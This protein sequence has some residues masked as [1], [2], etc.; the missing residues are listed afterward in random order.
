MSKEIKLKLKENKVT[1]N[2]KNCEDGI[3]QLYLLMN[4]VI[5]ILCEIKLR[6]NLT[7]IGMEEYYNILLDDM[8][9][10]VFK[11]LEEIKNEKD[12]KYE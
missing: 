2:S 8:K 4:G 1:L 11:V 9:K 5:R 10:G 3:E 12:I 7:D 6:N